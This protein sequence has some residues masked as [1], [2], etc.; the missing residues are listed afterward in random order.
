ME[1]KERKKLV[2]NCKSAASTRRGSKLSTALKSEDA[3]KRK[4][5]LEAAVREKIELEKKAV[6]I[7]E[8]LLEENIT[9]DF[10]LDCGKFITPE[11]YRDAVEERFLIKRCGYPVCQTKLEQVLKQKFKISTKTNRVYDITE[12]KMF[13][14][15]FCYRASKYFEAQVPKSP[16]WIREEENGHSGKQVKLL[17]DPIKITDIES[18]EVQQVQNVSE[19]SDSDS[20]SHD[21]EQ[22]F[23]S[24]FVPAQSQTKQVEAAAAAK[25][26]LS[27]VQKK[28]EQ[29]ETNHWENKTEGHLSMCKVNASENSYIKNTSPNQCLQSDQACLLQEHRAMISAYHDSTDSSILHFTSRGVSK[30]GAEHLK[31][32]L[33]KSKPSVTL[34]VPKKLDIDVTVIKN[35]VLSIL[36][37]TLSEW[38]T[39]D[40]LRYLYGSLYRTAAQEGTQSLTGKKEP[41]LNKD[42]ADSLDTLTVKICDTYSGATSENSLDHSLP[43]SGS[44]VKPLPK[45][46]Q[47]KL[48]SEM[49]QLRIS[50]F[51]KGHY[52]LPEEVVD[53]FEECQTEEVDSQVEPT[54]PLVDSKSQNQLRKRI[55]I[56]KL[57]KVLPGILGPMQLSMHDISCELYNLVHT[58]RLTSKNII[59]NSPEWSV[60]ALVLLSVLSPHIPLIEDSL[61]SQKSLEMI[62]SCLK[63]LQFQAE[64]LETLKNVF[65][66]D[67]S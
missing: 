49:M 14:S 35:R 52:I 9:E 12:R 66:C 44:A 56:E 2:S 47:L 24:T 4:E 23:V 1:E 5:A 63:E 37:E 18:P 20:D 43:F 40:T 7:V 33:A 10:L 15:N 11:H 61:K 27:K 50:E 55:V 67:S 25:H 6:C 36:K 41:K 62:S 32:L 42:L 51:F 22:E 54:L 64:D 28:G 59:H 53:K 26:E 19:S 39:D 45:Y 3:A 31:K 8:R 38:R 16:L 60:I 58:F 46:E 17:D 29:S 34:A 21:T 13:C 65:S 30:R 48:E 57:K